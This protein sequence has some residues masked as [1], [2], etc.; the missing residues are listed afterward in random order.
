MNFE[1]FYQTNEVLFVLLF[2]KSI[3]I[4]NLAETMKKDAER[5]KRARTKKLAK[6]KADLKKKGVSDKDIK[7][8]IDKQESNRF[9]RRYKGGFI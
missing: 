2:L 7:K 3:Y 1:K 9:I 8:K 6:Q 4:M 5:S